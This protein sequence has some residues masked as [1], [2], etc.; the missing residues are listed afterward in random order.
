VRAFS[1]TALLG[2]IYLLFNGY[3]LYD[4]GNYLGGSLGSDH[5]SI[6]L[7]AGWPAVRRA[8]TELP[9]FRRCYNQFFPG[10]G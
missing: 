9:A 3:I 2:I 5:T 10:E 4:Y 7:P 1:A 6:N 8:S